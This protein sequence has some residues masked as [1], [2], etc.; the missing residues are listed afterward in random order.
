MDAWKSRRGDVY[1][2]DDGI[3]SFDSGPD[4]KEKL[5]YS[6]SMHIENSERGA[7]EAYIYNHEGNIMFAIQEMPDYIQITDLGVVL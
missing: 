7:N 2:D 6:V 3:I 4:V 1:V 5:A